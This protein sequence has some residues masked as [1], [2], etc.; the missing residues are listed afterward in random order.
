MTW[1]D[2]YSFLNKMANDP[3]NFGKFDWNDNVY[4]Y[5][6]ET[7]YTSLCDTYYLGN[8]LVLASN[9]ENLNES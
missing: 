7:D 2:L 6:S 8:Q 5:D 3:S 1:L 4:T 9:M